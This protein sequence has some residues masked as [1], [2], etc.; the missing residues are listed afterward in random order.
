MK[1]DLPGSLMIILTNGDSQK[2]KHFWIYQQVILLVII[3]LP[4]YVF[5]DQVW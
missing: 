2:G 1:R 4:F 3:T 5:P